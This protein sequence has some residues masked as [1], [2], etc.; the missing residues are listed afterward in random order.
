MTSNASTR[1]H[2]TDAQAA[3]V[4]ELLVDVDSVELKLTIPATAHR[5]T[6]QGLPLDPV[7]AEPRQVYFFDTPDLNLNKA[8]VVVRARRIQGGRAD[9]VVKLRP[10]V[11][12]K[13][14]AKLRRLPAFGVELDAL[15]SGFACSGSLKGGSTGDRV[16]AAV[17]GR[18]PLR[19]IFSKEQ[20]GFYEQ[21]AP[22]GIALDSLLVLGP[23]FALK[24]RFLVKK[25]GRKVVAEVWLYPD[26]SRILELSTKCVPREAFQVAAEFRAYLAK[27]AI[28][29]SG[30]QETKTKAALEFFR[31]E[32]AAAAARSGE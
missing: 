3:E 13:L 26:G 28:E 29:I 22:A 19:K 23:T 17:D 15:P 31:A 30:M 9:T 10:V 12:E 8:G 24:S 1:T 6:I 27:R 14:P 25:L 32:I 11:P 16:R 20:R 21:S 5:A 4:L 7:E 18:I 2:L